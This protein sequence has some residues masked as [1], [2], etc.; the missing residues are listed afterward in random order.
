MP[1]KVIRYVMLLVAL[2]IA[3]AAAPE[4]RRVVIQN[5]STPGKQ[6]LRME[7][8]EAIT[9]EG[10]GRALVVCFRVMPMIDAKQGVNAKLQVEF[11][12]KQM[13][14]DGGIQT[15]QKEIRLRPGDKDLLIAR[16]DVDKSRGAGDIA[17]LKGIL[18]D[19]SYFDP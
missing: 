18:S 4:G 16:I 12:G 10:Q 9:H 6:V 3:A 7:V 5:K 17:K 11:D 2:S 13:K 1:V 19:V 14:I 8:V 15:M